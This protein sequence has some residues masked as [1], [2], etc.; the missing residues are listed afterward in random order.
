MFQKIFRLSILILTTIAILS[1]SACEEDGSY[2]RGYEEGYEAALNNAAEHLE[3][4]LE[5]LE[6]SFE[7]I[8]LRANR[9]LQEAEDRGDDDLAGELDEILISLHGIKEELDISWW[10]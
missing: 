9:L 2:E 10:G 1:L 6:P 8:E 4:Q 5:Y 3:S 7:D